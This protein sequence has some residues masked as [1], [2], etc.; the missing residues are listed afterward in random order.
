MDDARMFRMPGHQ[1]GPTDVG[2]WKLKREWTIDG[3]KTVVKWCQCPMSHRF[4]CKCQIRIFDGPSYMSLEVRSPH[5]AESHAP[6]KEISKHLTVTQMHALATGVHMCP[7]QSGR[8]L[9]RNLANFSPEKRINP[10]KIRNVRRKVAKFR[11]D[12]TLEQLDN[13]KIDDS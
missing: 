12:L 5:D 1:P 9:R 13:V 3:G 10:L 6:D 4:G 7:A 11:A 8:S 2:L